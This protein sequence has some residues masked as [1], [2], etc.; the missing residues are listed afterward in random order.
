[1]TKYYYRQTVTHEGLNKHRIIKAPNRRELKNRVALLENQWDEEWRRKQEVVSRRLMN[2]QVREEHADNQEEAIALTYEA[3]EKQKMLES[4]LEDDFL[5]WGFDWDTL[6]NCEDFDVQKPVKP[7]KPEPQ[8]KPERSDFKYNKKLGFIKLLSKDNRERNQNENLEL[9]NTDVEKWSQFV[10]N[11]EQRYQSKVALYDGLVEK[12]KHDKLNYDNERDLENKNIDL[13]REKFSEGN[14]ESIEVYFQSIIDELIFPVE[15]SRDSFVEYNVEGSYLIVD[16]K[17]PTIEDLPTIKEVKYIKS[18]KEFKEVAFSKMYIDK[19]YEKVIYSLVLVVLKNIF[20]SDNRYNYVESVI[21]NGF[22]ETVDLST[23]LNH[24]PF[25]LST[26]VKKSD[27]EII[28]LANI[29]P[30]EWFR[31]NKGISATKLTTLTP[32]APIARINREDDRFVDGYEVINTMDDDTNLASLDWMDFENLIRELFEKEFNSNGGEVKITQ[33]S[34]DGGVDAVAFDPDPLKGGKII[35]QAKRYTN[36]VGVSAVRDLYGTLLNEGA[37]KGILVTTSNYGADSYGFAKDKP[38]T[39]I[40]GSEL[41]YM[42]QKHGHKVKIDLE[43]ARKQL[44]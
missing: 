12:W 25:I 32:V 16:L 29:D 8:R 28:N 44:K 15:Y 4:I 22:I 14:Q 23:G 10:E 18:R 33:A 26:E 27:F 30:K 3:E 2:E 5:F 42:L 13:L 19:L 11:E 38:I 20:I 7:Q 41:L 34:R 43:E 6:K 24:S 9:F 1:M 40:N 35:I 17:L 37:N 36:V 31:K 21:M 39:L